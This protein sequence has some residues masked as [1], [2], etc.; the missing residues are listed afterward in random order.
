VFGVES[1][2]SHTK[3]GTGG[4]RKVRTFD[5]QPGN[6]MFSVEYLGHCKAYG[7]IFFFFVV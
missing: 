7:I 5:G 3:V 1:V 4:D 2:V 6:L